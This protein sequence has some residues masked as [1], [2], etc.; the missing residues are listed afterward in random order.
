MI[1]STGS[2]DQTAEPIAAEPPTTRQ[3]ILDAARQ[4]LVEEGLL[5]FS[6]RRVASRAKVNQALVHY[7][8]GSTE[9]LMLEVLNGLAASLRVRQVDTFAGEGDL[10][11]KWR[12]YVHNLIEIDLPE[13]AP[14]VWLETVALVASSERA[15]LFIETIGG[16]WYER[17]RAA[18]SRQYPAPN[19]EPT[20]EALTGLI[21][22]VY[23]SI[24][25]DRLLGWQR[26]HDELVA[27][28][29]AILKDPP[30]LPKAQ[31]SPKR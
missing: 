25:I 29:D 2:S 31:P 1:V 26:G 27:L 16:P 8:F 13:G 5:G 24:M 6:T 15:N 4:L 18:V 7:H 12:T 10:S 14:K 30:K 28:V 21:T 9:N 19:D 20:V 23:R 3:L 22:T 11:Y 17:I